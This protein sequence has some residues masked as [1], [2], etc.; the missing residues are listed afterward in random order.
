MRS[1]FHTFNI[2]GSFRL[3]RNFLSKVLTR[4]PVRWRTDR[5]ITLSMI[6]GVT[7]HES[8]GASN[9]FISLKASMNITLHLIPIV[10][11]I[12]GILILVMPRLL[13][14]IVAIYLIMVGLV[15]LFGNGSFLR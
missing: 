4:I 1:R 6:A 15:G 3:D 7:E 11:L 13:S 10:S 5:K 14:T 9:F 2:P 8:A 12:A